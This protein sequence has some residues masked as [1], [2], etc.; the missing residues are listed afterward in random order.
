[1]LVHVCETC[2]H[3]SGVPPELADLVVL[4]AR[5]FP[6]VFYCSRLQVVK[7]YDPSSPAKVFGCELYEGVVEGEA[8]G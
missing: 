8:K 6:K 1:M 2:R 4:M 5:Y 7:V 3:K